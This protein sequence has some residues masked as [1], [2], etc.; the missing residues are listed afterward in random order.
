MPSGDCRD[1]FCTMTVNIMCDLQ[2][3]G[4]ILLSKDEP[5]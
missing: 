1:E 2:N 5:Q 3:S 4:A